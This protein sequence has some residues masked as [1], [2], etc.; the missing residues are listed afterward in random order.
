MSFY[1][2]KAVVDTNNNIIKRNLLAFQKELQIN[3]NQYFEQEDISMDYLSF[4]NNADHFAD[5]LS[6]K[7]EA[8]IIA[9]SNKGD[10]LS[11]SANANGIILNYEDLDNKNMNL[12]YDDLKMAVEKMS[13]FVIV[14]V[15]DKYLAVYA[16]P[17]MYSGEVIGIVRCVLNYSEVFSSSKDLLKI[18]NTLVLTIFGAIFL[19][20]VLLSQKITEPIEKLTKA[21]KDVGKGRFDVEIDVSSND[22]VGEL[23]KSFTMMNKQIKQQIDIIALDRDNLRKLDS[24]RKTFFDNITH[25]MKTPLTI[26]SGYCQILI[27]QKFDDQELLHKSIKK[28]KRESESM[29]KMVLQLLEASKEESSIATCINEEVD[30]SQVVDNACKDMKLK[31]DKYQISIEKEIEDNIFVI[32]NC[33]EL[34]RVFINLLDN[35]IKYG[36]VN[37]SIKVR[38]F[39]ESNHCHVVIVDKG[40]GIPTDKLDMIFERFY[41]I[42]Q[43][44]HVE[45]G[46][47]GLGLDIVKEIL[48]KYNG[49]IK[50]ISKEQ[51]GT[52]VLVKIPQNVYKTETSV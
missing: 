19:F 7:T 1:L 35:A 41:R 43:F 52:T 8:R 37:S 51:I 36:D 10:F 40:K 4:S 20:V 42:E 45:A 12:E 9:Y 31:A 29:H 39:R 21:A 33:D 17:V 14:P 2:N 49:E 27:D 34:R 25:E 30:L 24:F 50:I 32:G 28:I 3:I 6:L 48:D 38:L 13:S 18:I 15:K 26:I 23:A 44:Q 11:D 46:S 22:E 5:K 47:Y 16:Y